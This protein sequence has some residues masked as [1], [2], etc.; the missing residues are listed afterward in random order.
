MS[1]WSKPIELS[2]L[3]PQGIGKLCTFT[4]LHQAQLV[5]HVRITDSASNPINFTNMNGNPCAFP[6]SGSGTRVGFFDD[7]AGY[8][9]LQKG[10]KLQFKN[11]GP[12]TSD[13]QVAGP[14]SFFIDD[15]I[16]G[17]GAL[18]VSEDHSG[19]EDYNDISFT[20]Q[21]YEYEG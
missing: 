19:S 1:D 11:D 12:Q 7:G 21:W 5:Q 14:T 6:V 18:I 2:D 4:A 3:F 16:Y 9:T 20:I 8:F 15:K 10:Y 17:G 13:R